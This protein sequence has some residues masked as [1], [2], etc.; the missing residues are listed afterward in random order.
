MRPFNNATG[1]TKN[2][3]TKGRR[4]SMEV[5]HPCKMALVTW[6]NSPNIYI[7]INSNNTW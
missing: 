4:V 3:Q 7:Y 5:S 2:L 6:R 1:K